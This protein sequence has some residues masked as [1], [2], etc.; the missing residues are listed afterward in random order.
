MLLEDYFL[1]RRVPEKDTFGLNWAA[2]F[3]SVTSS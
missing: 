1:R 3:A 2:P